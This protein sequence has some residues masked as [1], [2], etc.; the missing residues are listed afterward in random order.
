MLE[1]FIFFL[2]LKTHYNY[3]KL[4][5]VFSAECESFALAWLN[6]DYEPVMRAL[7]QT[8]VQKEGEY[9][10]DL[11]DENSAASVRP[12]KLQYKLRQLI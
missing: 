5:C 11:T 12:S 8:S 1:C 4:L 9:S 2:I 7:L 3:R 10:T 6:S